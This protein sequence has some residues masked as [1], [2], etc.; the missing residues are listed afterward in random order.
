MIARS[1]KAEVRNPLITLPA[2]EQL[3]MLS[4]DSKLA[5]RMLLLD[6]HGDALTR[7]EK[8]WKKSKPP[9]AAYWK[10]V[11]VYAKHTARLLR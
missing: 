7:A 5:L 8:C 3:C 11:A 9:M 6:L 2:F 1:S 4:P 10:A